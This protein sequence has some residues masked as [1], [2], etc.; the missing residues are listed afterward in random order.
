MNQSGRAERS[1]PEPQRWVPPNVGVA[2]PGLA[3]TPV[4]P[5]TADDIAA[6]E[7]SARAAGTAAGYQAGYASGYQ[8]G[9][10]Q[11]LREAEDERQARA[12]RESEWSALR[13]STLRTTVAALEGIAADLADPLA[14]SA[15]ALEPEL[16]IL[17]TTLAEKIVMEELRLRPELVQRVLR[18]ALLQLP[19]RNHP[20]RI[21]VHPE[22]Q[23]ILEAYAESLGERMTW[24]ADSAMERGGCLVE[25][26]PS[27]IDGRLQTRLRQSIDAVWGELMPPAIV[28][29]VPGPTDAPVRA[30]TEVPTEDRTPDEET[31]GTAAEIAVA[32]AAREVG[33]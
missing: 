31:F 16:L 13:E 20:R 7:E 2:V 9:R 3:E 21:H 33:V 4:V 14:R 17:A 22:D 12:A 15:D 28:P 1:V 11:A 25:S 24:V 26:G 6:I 8:E 32:D 23:A 18:Q 30:S 19:S 27:R 29:S 10:D 5:P